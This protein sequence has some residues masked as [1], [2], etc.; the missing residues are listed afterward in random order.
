AEVIQKR[1]LKKTDDGVALLSDLHHREAGNL[2]TLFDFADGSTRL[3]NFKDRDHFIH[4]YPFV[5]YQYPLFQ[6]SI[7]ELS[8]HNAIE[9]KHASVGERSMLG[10][11]REVA[12]KLADVPVDNIVTF[13]LMFEGISAVLRST[14]QRSI[15]IAESNLG[16]KF[17][18]RVLKALFL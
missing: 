18:V 8:R 16:D 9:G 11:F 14:V 6:L 12:I 13:D 10:V 1:L 2:R 5:P 15:F 17:A 7:E 4:S 3:E